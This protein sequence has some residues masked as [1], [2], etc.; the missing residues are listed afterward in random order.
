VRLEAGGF[1]YPEYEEYRRECRGLSGVLTETAHGGV[2][3]DME[4]SQ[5][6]I[7]SPVSPEFFSVL[8]I[9]RLWDNCALNARMVEAN[10]R[11]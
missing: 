7:A 1:S 10:P 11:W 9:Q 4:R 2:L 8:G 5:F 6:V 3:R